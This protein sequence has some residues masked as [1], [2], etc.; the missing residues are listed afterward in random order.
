[1]LIWNAN[2]LFWPFLHQVTKYKM[3]LQIYM[4]SYQLVTINCN[5]ARTLLI[6]SDSIPNYCI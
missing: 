1:M 2:L 6:C 3:V 4:Y 5:V